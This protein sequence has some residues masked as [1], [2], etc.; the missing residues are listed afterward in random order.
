MGTFLC[1]EGMKKRFLLF[2]IGSCFILFSISCHAIRPE[3]ETLKEAW[4]KY[5]T[6]LKEGE[7]KKAFYYEHISLS[8]GR[9]AQKYAAGMAGGLTIKDF[10]FISI[11]KEG[12]GPMG[13]TPIKM[14]LVTNW[15]PIIHIKGD[16]IV[17][18]NDYWVKK[19][20]KWY[21]LRRGLTRFW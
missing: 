13:S 10:E 21:H 5:W 11:G 17:I 9:T 7:F 1:I 8:P 3:G 15:P 12:S 6:Y 20:N 14:R 2:F 16:R 19:N 18:K 4:Y